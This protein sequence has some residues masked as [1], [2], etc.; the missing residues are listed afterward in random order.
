MQHTPAYNGGHDTHA[1]P[2]GITRGSDPRWG[3]ITPTMGDGN[4][5]CA[6]NDQLLRLAVPPKE[7][8]LPVTPG[9]TPVPSGALSLR[10]ASRLLGPTMTRTRRI[11]DAQSIFIRPEISA[12][13]RRVPRL[14]SACLFTSYQLYWCMFCSCK[15]AS[16][17]F[18]LAHRGFKRIGSPA[19]ARAI[20]MQDVEVLSRLQG[21]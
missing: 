12:R 17:L 18:P 6:L 2:V 9:A 1:V 11:I 16:L 21:W 7:P 15:A 10:Q 13:D 20:A 19:Q 8:L 5:F 3:C 4:C 14:P